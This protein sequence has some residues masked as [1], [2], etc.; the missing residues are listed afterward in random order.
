VLEQSDKDLEETLKTRIPLLKAQ[1]ELMTDIFNTAWTNYAT[2]TGKM[3]YYRY[4]CIGSLLVARDNTNAT[5]HLI[6][7]R[8]PY[9]VHYIS[10]NMCE[11]TVNLYYIFDDDA[12]REE[13]LIRYGE[14]SQAVIPY[15]A[16]KTIKKYS[17]PM[18]D[19]KFDKLCPVKEKEFD[20]HK[21]KYVDFNRN[22]WSGLTLNNMIVA[23]KDKEER[24]KETK[25]AL[26]KLYDLIVGSNNDYLH[27]SWYYLEKV[28]EDTCRG[29]LHSETI[30][31]TVALFGAGNLIIN[32]VLENFPKGRPDFTGRKT[33]LE[34]KWNAT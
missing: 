12:K 2:K 13:R 1:V 30:L 33:F 14:S 5:V 8:L 22:Y 26:L 9:Q 18:G 11:L 21:K 28:I 16:M 24:D 15:K 23:L 25:D 34:E 4:F 19:T 27:P 29:A 31:L 3:Y 6:E 7:A 17:N 10:R 20:E 32:K